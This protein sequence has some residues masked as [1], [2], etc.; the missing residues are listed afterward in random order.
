MPPL[1][2]LQVQV[3]GAEFETAEAVPALQRLVVGAEAN[4]P[5]LDVPQAPF[6]VAATVVTVNEA[7]TPPTV[8]C[9]TPAVAFEAA[10]I[11]RTHSV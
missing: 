7:D 10:L 4:T 1:V 8:T 6:T 3:H 2:P 5:P 11:N 9:A